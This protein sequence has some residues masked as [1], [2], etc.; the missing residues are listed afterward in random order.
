MSDIWSEAPWLRCGETV[1]GGGIPVLVDGGKYVLGAGDL[2]NVC[3]DVPE[4]PW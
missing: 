4:G 3:W 1:D 2:D